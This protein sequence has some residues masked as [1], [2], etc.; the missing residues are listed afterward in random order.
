MFS[1]AR[2]RVRACWCFCATELQGK[3]GT[4]IDPLLL[5]FFLALVFV[6][7]GVGT[8]YATTPNNAENRT[9]LK[10]SYHVVGLDGKIIVRP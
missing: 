3:A 6:V 9:Q 5:I 4:Q 7:W 1:F 8:P 10:P 2:L